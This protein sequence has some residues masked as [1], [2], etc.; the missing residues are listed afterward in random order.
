M[1][2]TGND[3]GADIDKNLAAA[4]A[5]G[6]LGHLGKLEL[7]N[8]DLGPKGLTLMMT[9]VVEMKGVLHGLT[10]LHVNNCSLT[11]QDA[12]SLGRAITAK[13]FPRLRQLS[14]SDNGDIG[15]RGWVSIIKGLEEGGC[16]ELQALDLSGSGMSFTAT[17][18]FIRALSSGHCCNLEELDLI[19]A[20][21][22]PGP[23][24]QSIKSFKLPHMRSL[25]VSQ[26]RD[27][28]GDEHFVLFGEALKAGVF[29]KLE[30]LQFDLQSI[31]ESLWEALEAGSCPELRELL[32]YKV[33]LNSDS[34]IALASA[35]ASGSLSKLQ[36]LRLREDDDD[37]D[38]SLVEVLIAMASSCPDLRELDVSGGFRNP[39]TR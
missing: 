9:K 26:H 25:D 5:A 15:E 28:M 21:Q 27:V 37:D 24:F 32:L 31:H 22:D 7:S 38:T 13:A 8:C 19:Y 17:T 16:T 23:F 20:F 6:H 36:R 34:S 18:A 3:R 33:L 29:P 11:S 30:T 10:K 12:E 14:L 4:L 35:I 2:L 39:A 1:S